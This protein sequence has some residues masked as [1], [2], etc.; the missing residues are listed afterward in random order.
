MF[1]NKTDQVAAEALMIYSFR[2]PKFPWRKTVLLISDVD[3]NVAVAIEPFL[4]SFSKRTESI[5]IEKWPLVLW[6]LHSSLKE[7]LQIDR[8]KDLFLC[9]KVFF[10]VWVR[11]FEE[12]ECFSICIEWTVEKS[13]AVDSHWSGN[14]TKWNSISHWRVCPRRR[15]RRTSRRLLFV[16]LCFFSDGLGFFCCNFVEIIDR[17]RI[18]SSSASDS[19][20][21]ASAGRSRWIWYSRRNG[22]DA[23]LDNYARCVLVCVLVCV[24]VC[25][26]VRMTLERKYIFAAPPRRTMDV[27]VVRPNWWRRQEGT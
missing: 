26:C 1:I 4:S 3:I 6:V 7:T 20:C 9:W 17:I 11:I 22:R 10:M 2:Y 27:C 13:R 25:V 15:L 5:S 18:R 23:W 19:R 24:C 12:N 8:L 16:F 14:F 21:V